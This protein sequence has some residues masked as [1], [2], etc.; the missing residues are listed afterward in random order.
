M[1]RTSMAAT[2]PFC[3]ARVCDFAP[4]SSV[5]QVSNARSDL[6]FMSDLLGKIIS[7]TCSYALNGQSVAAGG[8]G[9]AP[10]QLVCSSGPSGY[11]GDGSGAQSTCL[12]NSGNRSSAHYE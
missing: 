7:Q 4:A 1:R 8:E 2:S 9:L 12:V 3:H 5:V 6:R 10:Q 11:S